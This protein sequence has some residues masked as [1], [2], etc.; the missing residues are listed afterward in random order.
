MHAGKGDAERWPL[1]SGGVLRA[2]EPLGSSECLINLQ[3]LPDS[4][5]VLGNKWYHVLL[6][7]NP[8]GVGQ[9]M[10]GSTGMPQRNPSLDRPRFQTH[11]RDLD[12]DHPALQWELPV[13][14]QHV[15]CEFLPEMSGVPRQ[16]QSAPPRPPLRHQLLIVVSRTTLKIFYKHIAWQPSIRPRSW[17]WNGVLDSGGRG[18][19]MRG[20][21]MME[22]KWVSAWAGTAEGQPSPSPSA[23]RPPCWGPCQTLPYDQ[24]GPNFLLWL[25]ANGGRISRGPWPW[26]PHL[27]CPG[28]RQ[29][30]HPQKGES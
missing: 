17:Y 16:R 25:V 27:P 20:A 26:A 1:S 29:G 21:G 30:P 5:W 14:R 23:L 10:W 18:W 11:F 8:Q 3:P 22:G 15:S 19:S 4:L 13:S 24:G 9:E 28:D 2:P 6:G 12:Q 7:S